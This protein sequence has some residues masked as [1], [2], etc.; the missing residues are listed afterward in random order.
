VLSTAKE[1][2]L[3]NC[4]VSSE[5][6]PLPNGVACSES[7]SL[8]NRVVCSETAFAAEIKLFVAN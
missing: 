1:F 7:V 3:P 6:V 2:S 8:S 4:V 5:L